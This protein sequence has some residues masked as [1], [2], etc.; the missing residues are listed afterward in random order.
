MTSYVR[1][2]AVIAVALIASTASPAFGPGDSGSAERT[3][4]HRR[5]QRCSPGQFRNGWA[6]RIGCERQWLQRYGFDD[7]HRQRR[8]SPRSLHGRS[9]VHPH[10]RRRPDPDRRTDHRIDVACRRWVPAGWHQG[11]N[12]P[13]AGIA[14]EGDAL[15]QGSGSKRP[16]RP[17]FLEAIPDPPWGRSSNQP[18]STRSRERS[19]LVRSVDQSVRPSTPGRSPADP[20]GGRITPDP[21][22]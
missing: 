12:R 3:Q 10:D 16:Q 5:A 9:R 13:P 17:A 22:P 8:D 20:T 4:R 6:D 11:R 1:A 14:G 2:A 18:R 19:S 15:D 21:S 7:L